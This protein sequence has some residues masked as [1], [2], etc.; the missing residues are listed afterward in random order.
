[1]VYVTH[2]QI[3]AMTLADRIVVMHHGEVVQVGSPMEVYER[4]A[5]RFVAGFIGAPRMN[6]I[7]A[8]VERDAAGA[9]QIAFEG[10]TP[11][12]VPAAHTARFLP[13]E[14]RGL[15]I[16]AR[17]EHLELAAGEARPGAVR[18]EVIPELIEPTGADTMAF[19]TL[20]GAQV[21]ARLSPAS[22]VAQGKPIA[23]SVGFERIY[24]IDSDTGIVTQPQ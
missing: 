2:D 22:G 8:R 11:W 21:M 5:T 12:A 16:G 6:F 14:G 15:E 19:F 9:L 4:P 20:G 13:F 24:A 17:P 23:L 10:A 18:L 3:E 7:P 1:V